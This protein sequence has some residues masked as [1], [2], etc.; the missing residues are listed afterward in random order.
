MLRQRWSLSGLQAPLAPLIAHSATFVVSS[1][2]Q[3]TRTAC[4]PAVLY[5]ADTFRVVQLWN[6]GKSITS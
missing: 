6:S 3:A 1:C 5:A 4:M 2:K